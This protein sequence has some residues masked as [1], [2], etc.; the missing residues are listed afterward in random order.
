MPRLQ[1]KTALITGAAQGIGAAI[2]KAFIEEDAQVILTDIDDSSG[3]A[4]ADQIGA[5][6]RRLNVS[7]ETDWE[8]VLT[9]HPSLNILVNNAGIT[10][11][12]SG[13]LIQ[14]PENVSLEAWRAVHAVNL[15]GTLL[16]CQAAIKAMKASGTGSIINIS[17]R[18]GLVGIP[19]AAAY[20]S[21]KAAIIN[22][23][24]TVALYCAQQGWSIR[25]NAIAPAAILTPI[26]EPM[27]GDGPDR[28]EKM[29]ALVADTPL[30]RFGE[31]AEVASLAVMLA[32][33]DAAYMTGE[34]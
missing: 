34:T 29:A 30:K 28:E 16:G 13:E 11:F 2:T 17:S 8:S 3:Q 12:E 21:S 15:D 32:S 7:S 18:S 23:T 19:G 24:R 9:A 4:Y 6:Y 27:L 14:D 31:P 33:D 25:C 5:T 1:N 20:A 22:H 26:W 10:G